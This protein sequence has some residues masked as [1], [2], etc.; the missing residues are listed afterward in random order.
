MHAI[1]IATDPAN[2]EITLKVLPPT[3]M[4]RKL[5]GRFRALLQRIV[6]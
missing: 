2:K 3:R 1:A 4:R 6:Q 5:Y